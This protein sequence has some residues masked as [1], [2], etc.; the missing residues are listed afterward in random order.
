MIDSSTSREVWEETIPDRCNHSND[1]REIANDSASVT[2]HHVFII[3]WAF[4]LSLYIC[5]LYAFCCAP[6]M[7]HAD[8]THIRKQ[9]HF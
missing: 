3:H 2:C 4:K 9:K 1:P 6:T 5:P 7:F 8:A